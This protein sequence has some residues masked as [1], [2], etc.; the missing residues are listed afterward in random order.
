VDLA[1]TS[2]VITQTA[3]GA[4]YFTG[5]D[6]VVYRVLDVLMKDGTM[7]ASNPPAS[8]AKSRVFRPQ[9]GLRRL[10]RFSRG[11]SREPTESELQRQLAT[12]EYL[13]AEKYDS[14]IRQPR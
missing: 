9:K 12:A 14:A 11:E 6:G 3:H 7:H 1:D 5:P 2:S 13:A 4:I 10:Y 8:W